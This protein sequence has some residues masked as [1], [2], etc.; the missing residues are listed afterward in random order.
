M[1]I[2]RVKNA[3][4]YFGM[5]QR[6][7]AGLR[8]LSTQ[9]LTQL[10]VGR[11]ELDGTNLFA[12]I[13]EYETK[14]KDKGKWEAHRRYFDIQFLV[15]GREAIGYAPLEFCH[16]GV[17]DESKD[18]QEILEAPGDFL[19]MHPGMFML[20]APQDAHMPGL[21]LDAP[22]PVRKVVVKVRV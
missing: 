16:L 13:S 5:S 15:S 3:M 12:I 14:P 10:A 8:W 2:D 11:Y 6:I 20:L 18:F 22:G 7:S 4:L 1:I 17:Y 21:A 19:T 9:D